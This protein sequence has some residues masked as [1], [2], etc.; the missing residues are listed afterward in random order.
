MSYI[1]L[2]GLGQDQSS[3]KET[4]NEM[5][6]DLEVDCPNLFDICQ[7]EVTY[8]NLYTAFSDYCDTHSEQLNIC[9]LSLGGI[10][11]L[12]YAINNPPKV[13]S[14]VLI[15]TQYRIPKNLMRFQSVIFHFLPTKA[16]NK[17]G[18]SKHEIFTLTKSMMDLNFERKLEK[19]NCPVLIV[20]GAN[21]KANM[22]ASIQLQELFA[23]SKLKI[24]QN[25]GHEVNVDNP[26]LLGE[27]LKSFYLK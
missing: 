19:I 15:G 26:E 10:L 22:K 2:H 7:N 23:D 3:W 13:K 4:L 20:C 14:L 17:T 16:F 27:V 11:A 18:L 9:G 21:D 1:F 8:N 6:M 5:N 25:A 12:H 24:I